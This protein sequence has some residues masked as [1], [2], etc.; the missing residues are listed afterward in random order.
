MIY[1]TNQH[2][3]Y[4]NYIN[5]ILIKLMNLGIKKR[6][7]F[8]IIDSIPITIG[9]SFY[10][11]DSHPHMENKNI[12]YEINLD[13]FDFYNF[14]LK[15]IIHIYDNNGIL[16]GKNVNY[17][18]KE[19]AKY[20]LLPKKYYVKFEKEY[21]TNKIINEL[22]LTNYSI[23]NFLVENFKCNCNELKNFIRERNR[24]SI[25]VDKIYEFIDMLFED[26]IE[27]YKMEFF[28]SNDENSLDFMFKN[29]YGQLEGYGKTK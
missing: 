28:D 11:F 14:S 3:D 15:G 25:I 24:D 12:I 9:C 26:Q 5:N 8:F 18:E 7:L 23:C 6:D 27:D 20:V 17:Y 19:I 13:H 1:Y 4:N 22:T 10:S 16:I 21:I 29:S 2:N